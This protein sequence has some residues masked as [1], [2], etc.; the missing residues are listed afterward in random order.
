MLRPA[1]GDQGALPSRS[2]YR[3]AY[4]V[5]NSNHKSGPRHNLGGIDSS[6]TSAFSSG[7]A[8]A[9]A[10]YAECLWLLSE[11][12]IPFL[13]GGTLAASAYTGLPPPEKDVDVFCRAGDYPRI[14]SHF[15]R[16]GYDAE[17]ERW[18]AK[19]KKGD[20]FLDVIFNSTI[21]IV[22]VTAPLL[23]AIVY[24]RSCSGHPQDPS[25]LQIT[26]AGQAWITG[27]SP[28][29]NEEVNR[30]LPICRVSNADLRRTAA[31]SANS[32]AE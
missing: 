8:R 22:S 21:A 25:N 4:A 3:G 5:N 10:F 2:T 20:L 11:S 32:G 19:I 31:A 18:I 26:A 30:L 27:P 7:A 9:E 16:F 23:L 17:D 29:M 24:G 1:G 14:L 13:V 12:G 15:R 28:V 6:G